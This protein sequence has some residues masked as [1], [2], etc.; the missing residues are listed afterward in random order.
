[1]E[2]FSVK[3]YFS[4]YVCNDGSVC[5]DGDGVLLAGSWDRGSEEGRGE[6]AVS[7]DLLRWFV[8]EL[9]S[10]GAAV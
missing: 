6:G 2:I 9:P 4:C 7:C 5:D 10:P 1:M 8:C 3:V